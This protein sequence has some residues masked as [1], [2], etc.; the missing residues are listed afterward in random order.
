MSLN[1]PVPLLLLLLLC[2]AAYCCPTRQPAGAAKLLLLHPDACVLLKLLRSCCKCQGYPFV[3][4]L[5][6]LHPAGSP[7]LHAACRCLIPAA[8]AAL[9]PA[10]TAVPTLL[11]VPPASMLPAA[12]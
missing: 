1:C 11:V 12:A 3:A 4:K 6:L 2:T 9:L 7:P 10:S 8:H 5:L